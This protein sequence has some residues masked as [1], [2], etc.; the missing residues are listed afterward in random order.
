MT[1]A[2]TRSSWIVVETMGSRTPTLVFDTD[3]TKNF[4]SINRRRHHQGDVVG[5]A[6]R[7]LV[8]EVRIGR[9]PGMRAVHPKSAPRTY[10]FGLPVFGPDDRVFAVQVLVSPDDDVEQVVLGKRAVGAFEWDPINQITY[11]GPT[12]ETE[13]LGVIDD[14]QVE[15]VSP[16]IFKHFDEFPKMA[17]LGAFIAEMGSRAVTDDDTFDSDLL[18]TGVDGRQ[19]SAYM[20]FRAV[21]R[22]SDPW[23]MRGV[24]HDISDVR[25]PSASA[26]FNAAL[27]RTAFTVADPPENSGIGHLNFPA[28]V[29]TEWF[30]EPP[31]PLDRWASENAVFHD[32]DQGLF[33]EQLEIVATGVAPDAT[34]DVRVR[35]A[36]TD[37]MTT[38]VHVRAALPGDLAQGLIRVTPVS[39]GPGQPP[40]AAPDTGTTRR[41]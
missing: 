39:P 6:L 23:L 12:I 22:G 35:F 41:S 36:D 13:I 11:H 15:R 17:E 40:P 19:R 21:S 37:W 27:V 10:L 16:E 1:K 2:D 34:F 28:K 20:T 9:Q 3:R 5:A 38:T 26:G 8:E 14:P 24:V 18:M 25:P 4:G 29:I 32:A 7:E 30:H 33:D 31:A